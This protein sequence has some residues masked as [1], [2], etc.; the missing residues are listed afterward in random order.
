MLTTI[1]FNDESCFYSKEIENIMI[2]YNLSSEL[3]SKL[4]IP[5]ALP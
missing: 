4:I 3:Y 1:Q 2:K 5:Y